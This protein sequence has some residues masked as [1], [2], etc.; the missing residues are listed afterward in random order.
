MI[1]AVIFD[2][3]KHTIPDAMAYLRHHKL[4]PI[5]A[6]HITEHYIRF[7]INIPHFDNYITKDAKEDGIKYIIGY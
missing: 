4:K 5:K 1:Q 6:P 2:K 3:S 7:R